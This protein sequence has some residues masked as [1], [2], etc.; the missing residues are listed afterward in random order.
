LRFTQIH[1]ESPIHFIPSHFLKDFQEPRIRIIGYKIN[2][3]SALLPSNLALLR[4]IYC[5]AEHA[6]ISWSLDVKGH[7]S[8]W[9]ASVVL[10][11]W[12]HGNVGNTQK[13]GLITV[14][15]YLKTVA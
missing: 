11:T 13:M 9:N 5:H 3:N 7:L 14:F 12:M 8:V 10:L 2:N 15:S 6:A 4:G 1:K